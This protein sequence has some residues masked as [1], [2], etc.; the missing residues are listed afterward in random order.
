AAKAI[1][2]TR[3]NFRPKVIRLSLA[4]DLRAEIISRRRDCFCCGY[5]RP[6]T[7]GRGGRAEAWRCAGICL[8]G[9]AWQLRLSRQHLVCVSAPGCA[10]LFDASQIRYRQLS[11]DRRRPGAILDRKSVV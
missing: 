8:D 3:N 11:A 6:T 9:G 2:P 4:D 1:A 5:I 7:G 10:A